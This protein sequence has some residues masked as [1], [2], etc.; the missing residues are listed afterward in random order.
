LCRLPVAKN[1]NFWQFLI[2]GGLLYPP[3]FSDEGKI[4]CDRADPRSTLTGQISSECVHYVGLRWPETTI[5][6]KFWHFG[7]P[8]PT[9]FYWWGPN[10]VCYNRPTV[11][12]YVPKFP[13]RSFYFVAL[14]WREI[15]IFAV[16]WTSAF[17]VV[18][19]WTKLNTGAQ[20]QTFPYPT[21]SKSFLY[22]Q[23]LH[24]DIG[25]TISDVHKRD[26]QTNRQ[27]KKTTFL[28]PGG[29]WNPSHTK[30]GMVIEDLERVLAP[31]KR[32]GSDA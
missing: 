8:V 4:W 7:A 30:L 9:P 17:R 13:S 11:D 28:A 29:E 26:E 21:A 14:C 19:S 20:L 1:H 6:G 5:L 22:S 16:F 24:G 3:P 25:R 27:T 32:L 10:V 31:L 12:A 2:F 18:A 15:P 23:R